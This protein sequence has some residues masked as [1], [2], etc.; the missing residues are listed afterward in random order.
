[1]RLFKHIPRRDG[2]QENE[3]RFIA[4]SRH[5]LPEAPQHIAEG[6][7]TVEV[8]YAT[9]KDEIGLLA[10]TVQVAKQ[11]FGRHATL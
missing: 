8:P 11:N 5:S 9:T 7:M 4:Q 10:R 2:K 1:M 3:R 6:D